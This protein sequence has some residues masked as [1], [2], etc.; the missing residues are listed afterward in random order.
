MHHGPAHDAGKQKSVKMG[1]IGLDGLK[2]TDDFAILRLGSSPNRKFC[3]LTARACRG[4]SHAI[5][6]RMYVVTVAVLGLWVASAASISSTC[7]TA[8]ER[9]RSADEAPRRHELQ[10][11][12]A[13]RETQPAETPPAIGSGLVFNLL[14][15]S[16]F[17][18]AT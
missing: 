1:H 15:I 9:P 17:S 6:K 3:A 2:G 12:D 11:A 13:P 16:L 8:V 7:S 5:A 4:D 10:T 14:T 18:A